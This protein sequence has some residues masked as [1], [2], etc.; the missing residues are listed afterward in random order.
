VKL[1]LQLS[2]V[3]RKRFDV[4][5]WLELDLATVSFREVI[6]MQKGF[7]VESE[8]IAFDSAQEWRIAWLGRPVL[9]AAGQP[10]MEDLL[11][12]ETGEPVIDEETKEPVRVAKRISDYGAALVAIWLAL[13][14]AG[15]AMPL[16]EVA[17]CDPERLTWDGVPDDTDEPEPGKDESGPETTS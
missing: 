3:D 2:D 9:D 15:I 14:R 1:K 5:D 10:V 7:T 16:T 6:A 13:R 17:D 12:E 11:D 4:P 8:L